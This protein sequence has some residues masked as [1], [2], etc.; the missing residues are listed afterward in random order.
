ML[1]DGE[2][3]KSVEITMDPGV[4]IELLAVGTKRLYMYKKNKKRIQGKMMDAQCLV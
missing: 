1:L 4:M 3:G 2:A